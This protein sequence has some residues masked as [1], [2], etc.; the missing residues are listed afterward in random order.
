MKDTALT[1]RTFT[2]LGIAAGGLASLAGFTSCSAQEPVNDDSSA[3]LTD[4][5]HGE[6]R[7]AP[8][9]NNC[10]CDSSR[11][12]LKVYVEDGV[13]LKIRT[14]EWS[15]DT[16]EV[17]QRRACLRGRAAIKDKLSPLRVKYPMKRKNW[18][19]DNPHGELRGID[20]WERISWE[21]ALDYIALELQKALDSYG[22]HSLL[23]CSEMNLR[24]CTFDPCYDLFNKLGAMTNVHGEISWGAWN[25]PSSYMTGPENNLAAV[26]AL[27]FSKTQL[28]VMFGC[29]WTVNKSGLAPYQMEYAR[30]QGARYIII[31]PW[32]NPTAQTFADEW[33]PIVPGTDTALVLGIAYHQIVNDL[34]D[35]EYLDTYCIGFDEGHMPNDAP[36]QDNFKDYVL[37]TYDNEPKSPEW[38][39]EICHVPADKIRELAELIA[40]TEKVGFFGGMST[41]K[42]P[43]GEQFAQALYTLAFMQG[44]I[45]IEGNYVSWQGLAD[46]GISDMAVEGPCEDGAEIYP[47]KVAPQPTFMPARTNSC[48]DFDN[49]DNESWDM[50]DMATQWQSILDGEYGSDS[51]PGGKRKIDVHVIH[52]CGVNNRLNSMPNANAGIE[53][54]R[55]MDF[56][57]T[58]DPIF[59]VSARYSDIVLPAASLWE[60]QPMAWTYAHDII[61]WNDPVMEPLYESMPESYICDELSKRLGFEPREINVLSEEE[62]AYVSLAGSKIKINSTTGEFAPMLT[63]EKEDIDDMGVEGTPQEGLVSL[64]DFK[65]KGF[66]TYPRE[67]GDDLMTV[68]FKQYY[69]DPEGNPVGT[70][71]GKFEIYCSKLSRMVN[72]MGYSTI[73]PIAKWHPNPRHGQGAQTEE[74]PLLL[75]SPHSIARAHGCFRMTESLREAFPQVCY[76]GEIDAV[77]RGIVSGDTVLM[78]SPYGQVLRR[79]KVLSGIIPG[80]VALEDGGWLDIDEETGIDKG[81]CPNI[82]QAPEAS[83]HGYACWTGGLVEVERYTGE[84]EITA[85]KNAPLI[86]PVG[87]V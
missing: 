77:E 50:L 72:A 73:D 16:I 71:S 85:D 48:I 38:A 14:D 56:V 67:F 80:A 47:D 57:F 64:A 51:W 78:K 5:E 41:T 12:L 18:S 76:I 87:I 1:R 32:L 30:S 34:F 35:Q 42:H 53:V 52:H 33:I 45:G 46:S 17:P 84:L 59:S 63:I 20:E 25:A 15:E 8:C 83:G 29:N 3:Q 43:S 11:C 6:W 81:G 62:R 26:D 60:K 10:S 39:E 7:T 19:P 31:D 2:K 24:N 70:E 69:E 58:Q 4:Q 40:D 13:P 23:Q 55:K 9:Y 79:A 36:A 37:G 61:F 54:H 75:W 22:P 82:L 21:E 86:V 66:Y 27:T 74:Y 49:T 68:P 65:E 44:G 28:H